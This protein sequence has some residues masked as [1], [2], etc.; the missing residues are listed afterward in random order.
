MNTT[1]EAELHF[2]VLAV[3]D[4]PGALS[5]LLKHPLVLDPGVMYGLH[6]HR[7]SHSLGGLR[8]AV[9]KEGW[10]AKSENCAGLLVSDSLVPR[11]QRTI[12]SLQ[13]QIHICPVSVALESIHD[14]G[15]VAHRTPLLHLILTKP[16]SGN[17]ELR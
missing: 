12:Y 10:A 9:A 15:S 1:A 11:T 14:G 6:E 7:S 17:A 2:A 13:P 16:G 8:R 5:G 4:A 3:P